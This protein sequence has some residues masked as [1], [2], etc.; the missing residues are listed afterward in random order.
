MAEKAPHAKKHEIS[1]EFTSNELYVLRLAASEADQSVEEY[2]YDLA[3]S[4]RDLDDEAFLHE[5]SQS[6]QSIK[7][8]VSYTKSKASESFA[9][10]ERLRAL[11]AG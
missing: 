5:L 11:R 8:R 4:T 1:I 6:A 3:T 10:I 7:D 9:E 2:L